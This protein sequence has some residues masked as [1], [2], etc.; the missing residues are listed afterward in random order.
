MVEIMLFYMSH[1]LYSELYTLVRVGGDNGLAWSTCPNRIKHNFYTDC[2]CLA[3][4]GSWLSTD[5]SQD[6]MTPWIDVPSL[7]MYEVHHEEEDA[8]LVCS[9]V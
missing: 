2:V 1:R 3:S 9:L 8:S 5:H 6:Q 4:R 7:T